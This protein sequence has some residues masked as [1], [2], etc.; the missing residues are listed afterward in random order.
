ML[1]AMSVIEKE[2]VIALDQLERFGHI[3]M[4]MTADEIINI[5][6]SIGKL[7]S[8]TDS[9]A[10]A[11]RAQVNALQEAQEKISEGIALKWAKDLQQR[12]IGYS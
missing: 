7:T 10:Q 9:I 3:D 8:K 1:E 11:I 12:K 6:V 5:G 4:Q 2:A